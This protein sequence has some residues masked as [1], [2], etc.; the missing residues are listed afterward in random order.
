MPKGLK[1]FQK[2]CIPWN[3]GKKLPYIPH[4]KMRGKVAW[5][6]N[7]KLSEETKRKIS[8]T[9]KRT[10]KKPPSHKGKT[11][12]E[13]YGEGW[14]EEI[15][16]RK[17]SFKKTFDKKKRKTPRNKHCGIKYGKWRSKVFQ[18]DNWICQTC[19]K[20]GIYL[21]AHHIK[22][23]AKYPKLR[24]KIDNGITLC[25][26]PCHKLANNYQRKL[27]KICG[28]PFELGWNDS[29]DKEICDNCEEEED[30]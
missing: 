27:E 24:Y 12:K 23:W 3:T 6:K 13:I 26:I 7:K 19:S 2:K 20:R 15:K 5:N 28:E 29:E 14:K 11:Y 18:R 9:N 1:G 16:K 8:E 25:R 17:L 30:L 22:S 10:G 21:E 4:L